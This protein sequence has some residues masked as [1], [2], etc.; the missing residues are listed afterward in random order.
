MPSKAPHKEGE[1]AFLGSGVVE[2]V[3]VEFE[4]A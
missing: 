4:P 2:G 3:D 1:G